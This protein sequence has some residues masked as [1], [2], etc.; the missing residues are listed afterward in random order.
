LLFYSIN[1]KSQLLRS[2]EVKHRLSPPLIGPLSSFL[3]HMRKTNYKHAPSKSGGW[4]GKGKTG[5]GEKGWRE[6]AIDG[7]QDIVEM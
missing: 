4:G 2:Y 7:I 3:G 6:K 1:S 5:C